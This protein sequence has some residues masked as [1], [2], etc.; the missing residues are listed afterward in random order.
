MKERNKIPVPQRNNTFSISRNALRLSSQN[1]K[2]RE[3][4][5]VAKD[6][7][8]ELKQGQNQLIE[9]QKQI[10]YILSKLRK[11]IDNLTNKIDVLI[12]KNY[13]NG[14]NSKTNSLNKNLCSKFPKKSSCI[15]YYRRRNIFKNSDKK[16][17]HR[18]RGKKR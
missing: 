2:R 12:K 1:S 14:K 7:I 13:G 6:D 17:R 16:E 9:G 10:I 18:E 8:Y 4:L 15:A 11:S 3:T 5:N